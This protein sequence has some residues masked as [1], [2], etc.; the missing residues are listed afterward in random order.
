MAR[1]GRRGAVSHIS[2]HTLEQLQEI[3]LDE[4]RGWLP[5]QRP[6]D[7][8]QLRIYVPHIRHVGFTTPADP[9]A[10]M[11]QAYGYQGVMRLNNGG[12]TFLY[13]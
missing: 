12:S 3:G 8:P 9:P 4:R 2:L 5:L 1:R 10:S 11:A 13:R 7:G 6:L